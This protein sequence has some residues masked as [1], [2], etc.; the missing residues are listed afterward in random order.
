MAT[1]ERAVNRGKRR[2]ERAIRMLG[3]E[4]HEA[5]LATG[6]SQQCVADRAGISRAFYGRIERGL[7]RDLSIIAGGKIAAV[8]G[9]D[10]SV[11]A[12]PGASPLRDGAHAKRLATI[13]E[14]VR[15][16]LWYRAEVGL[17]QRP[18][19]P[20]EQRAWDAMVYGPGG[21]TAVELE[22]R[23]R[24]AQAVGRRI[25]LKLRD[26]PVDRLLLALADTRANRLA[27]A[28]HPGLYANLSRLRT[29][30]VLQTLRDGRHPDSGIILV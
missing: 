4:Y 10:L 1:S 18:D 19:Q 13:L 17:L 11:R 5:R 29:S 23:V 12:Y 7:V 21:R 2:S 9:L 14:N 27:L 20:L 30:S 28:E 16:P 25:A 24:D 26:D 3:E 15:P 8:I 22:M 6:L